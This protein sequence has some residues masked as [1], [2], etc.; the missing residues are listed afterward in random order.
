[1][2]SPIVVV[3]WFD[4]IFSNNAEQ[5]RGGEDANA[6]KSE[7]TISD[8]TY[9]DSGYYRGGNQNVICE[10]STVFRVGR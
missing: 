10:R 3:A 1:M 6:L 2:T 8:Y 9:Y 7:Y 4:G 5:I